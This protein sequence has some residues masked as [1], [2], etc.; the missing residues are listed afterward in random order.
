MRGK[1]ENERMWAVAPEDCSAANPRWM[2]KAVR[3]G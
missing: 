1:R 3:G 2:G